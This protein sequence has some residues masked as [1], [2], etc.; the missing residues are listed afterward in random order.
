[1]SMR[2]NTTDQKRAM[3]QRHWDVRGGW[4]RE[5]WDRETLPRW[6]GAWRPAVFGVATIAVM[7]KRF[8]STVRK[9]GFEDY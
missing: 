5:Q 9:P 3:A 8:S 4:M 6:I 1:M 7:V 2:V